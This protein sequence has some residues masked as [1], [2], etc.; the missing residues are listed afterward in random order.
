MGVCKI[1]S[2]M[3]FYFKKEEIGYSYN[4]MKVKFKLENLKVRLIF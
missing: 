4:K 2:Y 1:I 3:F